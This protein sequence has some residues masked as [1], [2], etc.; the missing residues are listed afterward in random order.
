MADIDEFM[1]KHRTASTPVPP[2]IADPDMRRRYWPLV[3]VDDHHLEPRDTFEGR[4]PAAFADRAPRI[5]EDEGLEFW[6]FEDER[7]PIAGGNVM[8]SWD[9]ENM[10]IGPVR[11]DQMRRG[12]W[13]V[14][15]RVRDMDIAGIYASLCFPSMVFGFAGWRFMKMKDRDLG[16]ASLRAYNR[17]V[18][19][20]WTGAYPDRLI[21]SQVTCL[22]D[23]E[24]AAAEIRRNA[25]AGFHAVTFS[26]NPETLGLPSLYSGYW[27]P[28]FRACEETETAINL[29][30]GSSGATMLPSKDSPS[31]VLSALF[32]VSA[33]SSAVDWIFAKIPVR[34]PALKLV[35]SEGGIGWLPMLLDRLDYIS[36]EY[37]QGG[38][39]DTWDGIDISPREVLLRNFWFTAYYDPSTITR[40]DDATLAHVMYESDY[41]HADSSWPDTQEI[42]RLQLSDL[43]APAAEAVTFR[44]AC[45]LFEHPTPTPAQLE[46]FLAVPAALATS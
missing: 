7:V 12:A 23:V 32:T 15:E 41:P 22:W 1:A 40:L 36:N 8:K 44:N 4:M 30:V 13:D 21:P 26:E 27:D 28:F 20:G 17:W 43:P 46:Q 3:S 16:L 37:V 11:Y 19:E 5:V 45:A 42:L 2:V 18:L 9:P 34:F 38:M 14:H 29:H 25:E 31:E 35:L 39:T 24:I 6:L 10:H 33:L